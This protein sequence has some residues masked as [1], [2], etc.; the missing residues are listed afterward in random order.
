M[1]PRRAP[2]SSV[3]VAGESVLT[4]CYFSEELICEVI[5]IKFENVIGVGSIAEAHTRD[6]HVEYLELSH[7]QD[8]LLGLSLVQ[9]RYRVLELEL[10]ITARRIHVDAR[11]LD[12]SVSTKSELLLA[13]LYGSVVHAEPHELETAATSCPGQL[14]DIDEDESLVHLADHLLLLLL[15][16]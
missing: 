4:T 9:Y 16:H 8:G 2:C 3:E 13:H 11:V 5:A 14:I 10:A 15:P 12:Q 7:P 6:Q 1:E